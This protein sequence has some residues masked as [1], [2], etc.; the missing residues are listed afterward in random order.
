M[1]PVAVKAVSD[2]EL[3]VLAI[4]FGARDS[5]GQ[6]FDANT[7]I[8]DSAFGTPL[9]VYQHGIEQGA[10]E[11]QSRPVI[12]GKSVPGTLNKQADG[13]HV[14]VILDKAVKYAK[15]IM[16]A[17]YKRMVAVSSGSIAHLARLEINGKAEQ[18]HKDK[19]GRIAVWPLAEISLW[20][21]GN[22]NA[23]PASQF[24]M[25]LP[26]M[27]AMYRDAGVPFPDVDT[28][29]G[30]SCADE[31]AK[32]ARVEKIVEEAKQYLQKGV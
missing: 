25:A 8:M 26:A 16:D 29:G 14:R 20:E 1:T 24:A 18:Y 27:K 4:P 10:K 19:P 11:Y 13:W 5:D 30:S 23:K 15:A 2:W 31:A 28:G 17:A 6:Y 22:G 12:V 9:I 21:L 32:R 3:D 7:D